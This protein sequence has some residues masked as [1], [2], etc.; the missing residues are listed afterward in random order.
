MEDER[1]PIIRTYSKKEFDNFDE[2]EINKIKDIVN[3]NI[4][5][6]VP[7]LKIENGRGILEISFEMIEKS[8]DFK[9]TA[10]IIPKDIPKIK[11][12]VLETLY[13]KEEAKEINDSLIK[14]E[15]EGIYLYEIKKYFNQGEIYHNEND[16]F[17]ME[18]MFIEINYEIDKESYISIFAINTMGD[19]D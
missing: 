8:N 15:K 16:G 1:A 4:E 17:F 7:L 19:K 10:K 13:S 18:S 5:G 2:N 9:V 14:G 11:I 3:G 6:D 12:S